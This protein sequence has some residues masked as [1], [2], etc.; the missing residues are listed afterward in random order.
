MSRSGRR[1]LRPAADPTTADW[2]LGQLDDWGPEGIPVGALVPS[3]FEAVAQVL[4]PWRGP[5]GTTRWREVRDRL[6][7]SGTARFDQTADGSSVAVGELDMVT[8]ETLIAVLFEATSTPH[9][10]FVAVW[11]GWGDFT[12]D[13]WRSI[14]IDTQHRGHL[15]WRGELES[16]LEPGIFQGERIAAGL[17]WPQDRAWFV[18]T[19]IDL[20]W[21]FV[22]GSNE[23]IDRLVADHRLEAIGTR[24]DAPANLIDAPEPE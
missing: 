8:A 18:A 19:G 13:R 12:A 11:E 22:A 23:L 17:W 9:D 1:G 2:W 10:V 16:V 4:H 20:A 6:S 5:A 14:R 7:P 24:F 15:L 3:G 21:T